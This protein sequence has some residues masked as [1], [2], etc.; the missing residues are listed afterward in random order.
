MVNFVPILEI[1]LEFVPTK[2][3]KFIQYFKG[4]GINSLSFSV[5]VPSGGR[6]SETI[7]DPKVV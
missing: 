3:F 2:R 1:W 6:D 5:L 4:R 7:Q